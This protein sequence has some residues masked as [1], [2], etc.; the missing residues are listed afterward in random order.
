MCVLVCAS[1][2]NFAQPSAWRIHW[3]SKKQNP[4]YF[5]KN[6]S[7]PDLLL[8]AVKAKKL[9]PYQL[10]QASKPLQILDEQNFKRNMTRPLPQGGLI[11]F[12]NDTGILQTTSQQWLAY[13][14]SLFAV[15]E[16][17]GQQI[18]YLALY[19]PREEDSIF[20]ANFKFKDVEKIL[21]NNKSALWYQQ[22]HL[23]EVLHLDIDDGSAYHIA[24]TLLNAAFDDKI[25][26]FSIAGQP[27]NISLK[28]NQLAKNI[29]DR[30]L[31]YQWLIRPIEKKEKKNTYQISDLEVYYEDDL[32]CHFIARF[33]YESI[34]SL[35]MPTATNLLLPYAEAIKQKLFISNLQRTLPTTLLTQ[36]SSKYFKKRIISDINLKDKQ[37]E[38]FY[39]EENELVKILK[40]AVEKKQISTFDND[41]LTRKLS[42]AEFQE[43]FIYLYV[44]LSD[45]NLTEESSTIIPLQKLH[46]LHL[47]EEITF[48]S[49]GKQKAYERKSIA[50]ILP[51]SENIAKGIDEPLAYFAYKDVIKLL[52]KKKLIEM[53]AV[54][55]QRNYKAIPIYSSPISYK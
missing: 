47:I 1:T 52:K 29:E 23:G 12:E 3:V 26:A 16:S 9:T 49:K 44:A 6:K 17:Q 38:V 25:I 24:K 35:L 11:T 20:I 36:K 37:N 28:T 39:S 7:L 45:S 31:S 27:I 2:I 55:A 43:K 50:I 53:L 5:E 42:T 48:D 18:E 54:F 30:A 14:V 13:D 19:V 34:K 4:A 10:P 33:P 22:T 15:Y 40:E 8:A 41:S 21:K 32:G 51:S 46:K